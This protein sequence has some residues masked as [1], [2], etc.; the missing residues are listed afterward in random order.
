LQG[1]TP[2]HVADYLSELVE[3]T[4][5]DLVESDC[6]IVEDEMITVPNNLGMI[7]SFYY[8][9]YVTV[10]TFSASI[11]E[12][13]KLKGLLEIVS[14][15][16]EFETI[17]IRHH[18]DTL[19][20]RIYDRVPVKVAKAD[21]TS[22]YFKTFLLL[23]AHFS[24]MTLPPDLAIDQATILTKITGLLSACVDVMSSKSYLGCLGAMDLSQMVVQAVWDR[25][26]PLKQVPYFDADVLKRFKAKGLGSVY[27]IMELEDDERTELLQM[28]DRQ[29]ARVAQFVN[30][31]PNVE[32]TYAVEDADS[33]TSSD[34]ITLN[35][36]LDRETDEDTQDQV[37]DA[38]HFPGKK[39]VSWWLVVG[40]ASSKTLHAIKKVTVRDRLET[41]LD[42]TLPEGE[43]QLKLYLIC[44]SYAGADQDFDLEKLK[45][46]EGESSDEED[47]DDDEDDKMDED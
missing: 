33:L 45:V 2:T 14:S 36:T 26:S 32:V 39:M 4:I 40:D 1:T 41:K 19:L 5:N 11:K 37:A 30:S 17:P 16:H 24:R 13:T 15:A 25:D 23:Q 28:D 8:I 42:F 6:I 38:P 43:Y 29:L 44:D 7:A 27:D 22:P 18:E 46:A 31:Y 34:A 20:E 10:E 3:T 35:V 9:S 21:Y 12:T 47:S